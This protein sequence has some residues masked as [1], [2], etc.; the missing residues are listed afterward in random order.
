MVEEL[1]SGKKNHSIVF[2]IDKRE[3]R[4]RSEKSGCQRNLFLIRRNP[5]LERSC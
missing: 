5:A 2:E 4:V 1:V 3:I